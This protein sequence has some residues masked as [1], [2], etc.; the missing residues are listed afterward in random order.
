MNI[1]AYLE[2]IHCPGAPRVDLSA[3]A[4]LMQGHLM[5]VPFEN[6]SIHYQQPIVLDEDLLFAKVVQHRRGGF[7]YELNGLFAQLLQELGFAVT[8]IS[9]QVGTADGAFGPAFDHL[10]LLVALDE[11][12]LVDIGFGDSFGRPLRVQERGPQGQGSRAYKIS[13]QGAWYVL[14]EE[15]PAGL[16]D[17]WKPVY[18]FTPQARQL[19]DFRPMCHYHQT[20]PSSHFT[21]KRVCSR[22]TGDGR[23]TL[24]DQRLIITRGAMREESAIRSE[25]EFLQ[26]LQT[27]FLITI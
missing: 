18:R 10:A 16:E 11:V 19:A 26:A 23:I 15:T 1:P 13:R 21:Q 9:A 20:S 14:H 4:A 24:R 5:E 2:R 8:L 12:Y 6:L 7:C 25:E 17:G 22:A 3:L 27:H